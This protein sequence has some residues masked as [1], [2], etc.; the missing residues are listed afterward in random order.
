MG[1][2]TSATGARPC[3]ICNRFDPEKPNPMSQTRHVEP[4]SHVRITNSHFIGLHIWPESFSLSK[5][6]WKSSSSVQI[7][8]SAKPSSTQFVNRSCVYFESMAG[9]LCLEPPPPQ[10]KPKAET[11]V[12]LKQNSG[13]SEAIQNKEP[14][15][16]VNTPYY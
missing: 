13:L 8:L 12:L 5:N 7:F 3:R 10:K 15:L 14:V 1:L 6:T 4:K 9:P 11:L 2:E 16:G